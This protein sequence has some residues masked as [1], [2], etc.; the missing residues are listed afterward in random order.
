LETWIGGKEPGFISKHFVSDIDPT[1][2]SNRQR[3]K[4]GHR[5]AI[6]L[7]SLGEIQE[8]IQFV[9]QT[10]PKD[11]HKKGYILHGSL[12][13]DGFRLQILAFKLRERQDARFR[14]LPEDDL[15]SRLTTTVAGS[16]YYLSE[17]RNLIQSKEDIEK[18]WPGKNVDDMKIVTLDGGQVCVV[19][20]FAHLPKDLD[21]ERKGKEKA[22]EGSCMEG[23]VVS[24]Q[25]AAAELMT[26]PFPA[27]DLVSTSV[28]DP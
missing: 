15:P 25:E 14:R 24:C 21:D 22:T 28:H 17:I 6:S 4:T 5:A 12:R 19:G 16:D 9:E 13:T 18:L 3:R 23:A 8:H 1:G 10:K 20:G 27:P 26:D 7:R 11:Y 2:P